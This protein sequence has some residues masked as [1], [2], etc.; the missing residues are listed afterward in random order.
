VGLD[1]TVTTKVSPLAGRV[2]KDLTRQFETATRAVGRDVAKV[3][4]KTIKSNG[5][6]FMGKALTARSKVQASTKHSSVTFIAKPA[7]AW[8]IVEAG[9][10]AHPIKPKR[11]KVLAFNGRFAMS[12]KHPGTRGSHRWSRLE[13]KLAAAVN[14]P[15]ERA[16]DKAA[17]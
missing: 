17:G 4:V 7:G 13:P 2:S 8:A 10:K 9:T 1:I 16:Y 14:K 15:I 12:V 11:A 5:G 6:R 3:G